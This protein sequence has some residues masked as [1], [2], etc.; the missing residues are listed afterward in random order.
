MKRSTFKYIVV[1]FFLYLIAELYWLNDGANYELGK[2]LNVAL[3][4]VLGL[5]IIWE[6]LTAWKLRRMYFKMLKLEQDA[7][8]A[9]MDS[10]IEFELKNHD[11]LK[12]NEEQIDSFFVKIRQ[13]LKDKEEQQ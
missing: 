2:A 12:E 5:L 10:I 7:K 4:I 9:H 1:F 8:N 3:L 13:D 6:E 11:R